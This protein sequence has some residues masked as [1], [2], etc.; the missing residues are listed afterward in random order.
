LIHVTA[1]NDEVQSESNAMLLDPFEDAKLLRMG[2]GAGDFVGDFFART[3]KAEL[4]VVEAGSDECREFR[5]IE[6]QTR[7]DEIDVEARGAGCTHKVDN[8]GTGEGFA[9]SEVRLE[10]A[11]LG[12]FLKDA[13]P[14]FGGELVGA[15]LQFQGVRTIDA[16]ERA[17]VRE[18]RDQG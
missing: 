2:L 16:M 4:D 3:L 12:G 8:V 14:R 5:F 1:M 11:Q 10:D 9:A 15:G 17:A 18:F 7:G 6:R 13:G